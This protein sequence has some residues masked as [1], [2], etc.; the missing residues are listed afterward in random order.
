MSSLPVRLSHSS[1]QSFL[2]CPRLWYLNYVANLEPVGEKSRP[3]E[4]GTLFHKALE[5]WWT[6]DEPSQERLRLASEVF[7][8][9]AVNLSFEDRILGPLLMRGYAAMYGGDELRF[10]GV[11][12]AERK[13]ELPVLDLNGQPDPRMVMVAQLDVVGYTPEG[14]TVIV[15]HKT[16][17]SDIR[18]AGFWSRFEDSLQAKLYWIAAT[19]LGRTPSSA[20]IDVVRAPVLH[21]RLA[22][23]IERREFYKRATGDARVGDP[24]P[25]TR[26]VDETREE[27]ATRV[28]EAILADPEGYFTRQPYPYSE[29]QINLARVDLWSVGAMMLNVLELEGATPRN[30]DGCDKYGGRCGFHAAC[31]GEADLADEKL[32]QIRV[33]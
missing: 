1:I 16:T 12:I 27:F 30:P 22:T 21:R 9:G 14:E 25:G 7:S 31:F 8:Q 6:C 32:F 23:P 13:V 2:R 29:H 18:T 20:V 24:R 3:L 4:F 28:E 19:D 33:R 10:Q 15:E 17:S 11:P 5:V 26:L